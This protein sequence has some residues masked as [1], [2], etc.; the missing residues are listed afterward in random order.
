MSRY[1]L[2]AAFLFWYP[3]MI[4]G[5]HQEPCRVTDKP[6][7][8]EIAAQ[9]DKETYRIIPC[10]SAGMILFFQSIEVTT[11]YSTRWYFTFYDRNL[12]KIWV[13]SAPILSSLHYR[14]V[15]VREDTFYLY[16]GQSLS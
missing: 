1:D 2:L 7:R 3:W 15:A 9:S 16:G 11:D 8:I 13:K 12:Q 10:G 14:D 5:Q 4:S 6:L